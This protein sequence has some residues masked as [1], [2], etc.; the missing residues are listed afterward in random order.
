MLIKLEQ[1]WIELYTYLGLTP[2]PSLSIRNLSRQDV[3]INLNEQSKDSAF[4]CNH[5]MQVTSP[6]GGDAVY[7]YG[8]GYIWVEQA[9]LS[10]S[11]HAV[12]DLNRH[13]TT[14]DNQGF[15][16]VRVDLGQ[17]GFFEGREFRCFKRL[18]MASNQ[19][20]Y[21]KFVA[22]VDFIIFLEEAVITEG[23][24][25]IT[26]YREISND[27]G[28]W[29][30]INPIGRNIMTNRPSPLYVPQCALYEGG[31]FTPGVEVGPPILIKTSN[32]TSQQ[33]STP[34]GAS[35]ERALAAGTYY[36]KILS[37]GIAS[38]GCYYLEWEEKPF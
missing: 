34:G 12:V 27:A 19:T 21:F 4:P 6:F 24:L 16:R 33:T 5:E 1:T 15:G 11:N 31:T 2:G 7:V 35:R 14:S 25:D 29:T 26:A 38:V 28:T 20:L 30:K 9:N 23:F 3:L 13:L 32:A 17:T 36:I 37:S 8:N 18:D 22:P 10:L